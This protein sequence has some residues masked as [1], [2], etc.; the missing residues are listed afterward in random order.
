MPD[1]ELPETHYALSGDVNIAYNVMGDAPIDLVLVHGIV[2][3][4]EA[5][6]ELLPGYTDFMRRL[7]KF[8]RVI[9][10]DKRGRDCRTEF[11]M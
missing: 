6:H 3:H 10:F 2:S 8:A 9:T 4:I 5:M 1:F 7:A 11:P